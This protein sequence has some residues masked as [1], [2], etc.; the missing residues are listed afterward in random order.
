MHD[1]IS[2]NEYQQQQQDGNGMVFGIHLY[3]HHVFSTNQVI[4]SFDNDN[5]DNDNGL[6]AF[7]HCGYSMLQKVTCI[8]YGNIKLLQY[9]CILETYTLQ[10]ISQR[11]KRN[12]T[13]DK[14]PNN[15]NTLYCILNVANFVH[16]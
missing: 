8:H 4:I 1:F 10:E 16:C 12:E 7:P 9:C 3:L 5:D 13:M 2:V 14:L 11:Q 6:I 15:I